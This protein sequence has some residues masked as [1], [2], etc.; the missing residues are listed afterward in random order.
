MWC[1][2]LL[3]SVAA[4]ALAGPARPAAAAEPDAIANRMVLDFDVQPDGRYTRTLHLERRAATDADARR[5]ASFLWQYSPS[6]EQVTVVAAYT[7]KA[8]GTELP[9]DPAAIGD[10]VSDASPSVALFTDQR[11]KVIPFIGVTAGDSVVVDIRDQVFRPQ[12][13]GVFSF[14]VLFGRTQ[15]WDDVHV[16][17]TAPGS[18]KLYADAPGLDATSVGDGAVVTHDWR[19]RSTSVLTDDPAVLAPIQRLPRLLVS[20]AADWQQIGRA[21][22]AIALPQ[23]AVTRSI[24]QLADSLTAD[25]TGTAGVTGRR[26]MAERL[27]DWVRHNIGYVDV[28]LG[29]GNIAPHAAATVLAN[30]IGDSQDQATLLRALLAAK[31]IAGAQVLISLGNL[32]RLSIPV[33]F[34]QLNH[35]MLYLPEFDIYADPTVRVAR[36]GELPFNEYGKPVVLAVP[37]GGVV[38]TTPVLA[39]D[40][41]SMVLTITAHLTANDMIAGDS[42]T[43]ATGPFGVDL[44]LAARAI[45][46]EGSGAA[47]DAQLAAQ[48]ETGSGQFDPPAPEA[49]AGPTTVSGHFS[50]SVWPHISADDHRL[51]LPDGLRAAL[52]PGDLL[53]GPLDAVSLPATEATPCFPGR[54]METVTLDVGPKYHVTQLPPDRTIAHDAF[55]FRSHWSLQGQAV[56][57]QRELVS[58]VT[59]PLCEGKLRA[60]AAAALHEIRLDY[61]ERVGLAP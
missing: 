2:L 40:A 37:T 19:Y 45:A 24:Q 61:A 50:V 30:R 42:R 3:L 48:G 20:T 49:A 59:Q 46:A 13:P 34:A 55:T 35:V 33:S 4:L 28:S 44:R 6:R 39:P 1:R 5:L 7:R 25:V 12:L 52:R 27:Y 47:A 17:V 51:S 32:Y 56:T 22:A 26:A 38:R 11:E 23:A 41:A 54:Q 16:N 14:S 9:V 8:D 43:E 29:D 21:Y 58:R 57:V 15:A 18:L 10:V 36:F 60:E 31:G 53:I